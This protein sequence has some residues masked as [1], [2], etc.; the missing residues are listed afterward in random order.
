VGSATF[1][2]QPRDV[3]TIEADILRWDRQGVSIH[4]VQGNDATFTVKGAYTVK[5]SFEKFVQKLK[6]EDSG[7]LREVSVKESTTSF[8]GSTSYEFAAEV[9]NAW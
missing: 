9:Q 7:V 1:E 8:G 2:P 3:K 5:S 4:S 6:G